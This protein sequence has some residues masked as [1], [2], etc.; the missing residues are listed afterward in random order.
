MLERSCFITSESP[1][2][3]AIPD[4]AVRKS[5]V[6]GNAKLPPT[7]TTAARNVPQR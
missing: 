5:R 1:H 4:A 2:G 6:W 3:A 7:A